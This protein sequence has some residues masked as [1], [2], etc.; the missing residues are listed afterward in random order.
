MAYPLSII[1]NQS[2]CTGVF[3]NRLKLAKVIPLYKKDDNKSFGNYRPISL[4]SSLSKVFEKIFFDQLY[5]YLISN[6]L[7]FES[8]YGFRKQHSTELAALELTDQIRREIDQNKIPFSVFLDL[9][10]AFDTLNHHILLSKLAYM[11]L[12]ALLT[13]VQELFDR[14]RLPDNWK[15]VFL[16][17]QFWDLCCF[18]YM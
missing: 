8:Q 13:M 17:D 10:K 15:R 7:L 5:E 14:V 9:S 16:R 18:S 4:L 3:P 1:I 11:E 6:G 12:K 2:L